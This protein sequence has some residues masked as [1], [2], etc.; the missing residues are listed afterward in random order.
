MDHPRVLGIYAHPDDADVGAGGT[1]A[2]LV[3]EGAEVALVV[4]TS[5]DAG[6]FDSGMQP[7]M[8]QI[9][10]EEQLQAAACLGITE[11]SFL[12]GYAD[13]DVTVTKRLVRD[14]VVQMRTHRPTLI[15]TM[16]PEYNWSS[17][18][19]NHPDHRAVGA[20]AV[21]AVYPAARNPFAFPEL[22]ADGLEP[23]TVHEMWFQGH[24]EF[25]H[26]MPLS[27][28]DVER[29]MSAVRCHASQFEDVNRVEAF[30]QASVQQAAVECGV[31]GVDAAERF[32]RF[33]TG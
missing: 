15:T 6:G 21:E 22:A 30:I 11:V 32:F 29:K 19:A 10:R 17:V 24:K 23:W 12:D 3:R 8:A 20:A 27:K 18:A 14:L 7:Q 33:V 2:R 31:E 5:G 28:D 9:R 4:V 25:N 1:L 16:S 26:Y 13:G